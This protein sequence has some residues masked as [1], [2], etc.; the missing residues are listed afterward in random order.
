MKKT[1]KIE[2]MTC[3][4]C[5]GRVK[6]ELE[7]I[8]GVTSADVSAEEKRAIVELAHEVEDNRFEAAVAEAGY[9]VV[10]IE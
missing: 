7:E 8:C 9:E 1:I 3:G 10:G 5:A 2:G 6:K 4:H